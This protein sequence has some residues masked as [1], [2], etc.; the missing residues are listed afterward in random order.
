MS[1]KIL[2]VSDNHGDEGILNELATHY[3]DEVD[4]FIHCGDSEL[5]NT[6]LIWEIY[7]PV[8][9]NMD[10]YPY[11]TESVVQTPLGNIV[12]AHGHL[13]DVK[14]TDEELVRLAR[15]N[16]AKIACY[17]HTHIMDYHTTDG[18]T[19]INPGSVR[20]PRGTYPYPTYAL[21]SWEEGQVPD[22]TFYR[23]DHQVI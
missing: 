10:F 19:I 1:L 21:V 18:V 20:L 23:H 12:V 4:Y 8:K 9:G 14:Q 16:K 13:H 7:H 6:D 22:V 15:E 5:S 17:G 3:K 2:V 11:E